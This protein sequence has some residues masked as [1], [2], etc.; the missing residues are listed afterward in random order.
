MSIKT[1]FTKSSK[2]MVK[3]RCVLEKATNG[4]VK[5][6]RMDAQESALRFMYFYDQYSE[7]N[8]LGNYSGNIEHYLDAYVEESNQKKDFQNYIDSYLQSLLD[9]TALFGEYAF[10]KV[11]PN[12]KEERKNQVNKLLMTVMCVLLA[13]HRDSYKRSY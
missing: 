1:T 9:A 2:K 8:V 4:S 5:D 6:T 12:Y 11:S 10:R 3:F 13:K 7:D